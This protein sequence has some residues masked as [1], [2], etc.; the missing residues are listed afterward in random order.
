[1]WRRLFST[2]HGPHYD[3]DHAYAHDHAHAHYIA[4]SV[5]ILLKH[6]EA[7][8]N[9]SQLMGVLF[10]VVRT[11]FDVFDAYIDKRMSD[12]KY[13]KLIESRDRDYKGPGHKRR[14][15]FL[16]YNCMYAREIDPPPTSDRW[17][18]YPLDRANE[19][20]G[21][22]DKF[23]DSVSNYF[24]CASGQQMQ[25][26]PALDDFRLKYR[27]YAFD[28]L[29]ANFNAMPGFEEF[30]R[31]IGNASISMDTPIHDIKWAP[32]AM[33]LCDCSFVNVMKRLKLTSPAAEERDSQIIVSCLSMFFSEN[34]AHVMNRLVSGHGTRT[35][36]MPMPMPLECFPKY[37][38][39]IDYLVKWHPMIAKIAKLPPKESEFEI[40]K[41]ELQAIAE[42]QKL[43]DSVRE[44]VKECTLCN[45]GY[46]FKSVVSGQKRLS[47]G[48][49]C[50]SAH[51][52]VVG[53]RNQCM[54]GKSVCDSCIQS[55]LSSRM[56]NSDKCAY[57]RTS[58]IQPLQGRNVLNRLTRTLNIIRSKLIE[59][60]ENSNNVQILSMYVTLC[61]S[62]CA[63]SYP[64]YVMTTFRS[65][66]EMH[67]TEMTAI[68]SKRNAIDAN[69]KWVN[70]LDEQIKALNVQE[71]S[72]LDLKE[73][74]EED[75]E[76]EPAHAHAAP[77]RRRSA[78]GGG[79]SNKTK[80]RHQPR[81][82]RQ[83]NHTKSKSK[84]KSN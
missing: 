38:E 27:D 18:D 82:R 51:G 46:T 59:L 11:M 33:A 5:S 37:P 75:E 19:F 78:D 45:Q 25:N 41:H 61:H 73:E 72:D 16:H 39:H 67:R 62:P 57:C 48:Q 22:V 63:V 71:R 84:R 9:T 20:A 56:A 36:P 31:H 60:K 26:F 13:V 1:M 52:M 12:H 44:E 43:V 79:K 74:D 65:M 55:Q 14:R 23:R 3:H 47:I 10:I 35:F 4:T 8:Q 21:M 70:E 54:P 80:R 68:L 32:V 40:R 28:T 81:Q 24:M 2:N 69:L 7:C 49:G 83:G 6:I 34:S 66:H 42:V 58:Q 53:A 77:K 29:L 15:I 30:C 64:S 76:D 50:S 17:N